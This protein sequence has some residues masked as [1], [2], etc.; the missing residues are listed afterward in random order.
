MRDFQRTD[1]VSIRL[2]RGITLEQISGETKIR[3]GLLRA[4]EEGR[5]QELPG[6]IYTVNFIRQYATAIGLD[7]VALMP[8]SFAELEHCR[9][10]KI[11]TL[12]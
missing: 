1:L 5:L 12:H 4:I 9:A 11:K 2:T 3:I 10:V 6:G 8:S 7:G